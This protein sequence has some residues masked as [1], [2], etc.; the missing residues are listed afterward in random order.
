MAEVVPPVSTGGLLAVHAHPD[1]EVITTG[2]VL[3]SAAASGRGA[4]V[5]TCTGGELGEIVGAGMD[6]YVIRPRL[7]EVRRQELAQSLHILGAGR[8]RLLGYRDSGMM[9]TD[10]NNHPEAFWRADV[11]EAVG[12]LVAHIRELRPTVCVTYDAFGAYGH[13]DHIQAHRI[14]MLAV[15]AAAMGAMY[16]DTGS[17]WCTPKLYLATV[18]RSAIARINQ[19]MAARGLPSPFGEATDVEHI[20]MGVPDERIGARIDVR[21]ELDRKWDAL[22]A[23]RSQVGDESFFL[24]TPDDLRERMFGTEWFIR[25]RSVGTQGSAIASADPEEDLFTGIGALSEADALP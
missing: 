9:G 23:H 10:G 6:P 19:E 3:A 11:H 5:V 25:V 20:D 24:N 14:T 15:E 22:R 17:E 8:P 7:A 12:R 13:P 21:R 2:G 1:D 18:P 16:P 4:A